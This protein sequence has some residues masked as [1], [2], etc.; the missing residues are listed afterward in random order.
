MSDPRLGDK[1]VDEDGVEWIYAGKAG[2]QR[3][4][5][6]DS[7]TDDEIIRI[8]KR[9][10]TELS[11]NAAL[12]VI[13]AFKEKNKMSDRFDLEQQILDCWKVVED[14]KLINKTQFEGELSKDDLWAL[15]EGMAALY[16]L[17]FNRMWDT[18][19]QCVNKKDL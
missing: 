17:K 3:V 9:F 12:A 19:E 16:E 7:L 10:P 14:T 5:Q 8:M 6:P 1:R 11:F 15:L 2:W 13:E 18:F 4:V